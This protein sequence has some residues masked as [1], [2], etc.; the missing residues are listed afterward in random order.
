MSS[1][2]FDIKNMN[3]Q[4]KFLIMEEIWSSLNYDDLENLTPNWHLNVLE[5]REKQNN[6]ISI[7][8]S[9]KALRNLLK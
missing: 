3:T 4:E 1:F 9:K 8:E 5:E 2:T 6:F 7:E